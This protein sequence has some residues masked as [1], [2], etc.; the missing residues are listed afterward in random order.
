M[1]APRLLVHF[2]LETQPVGYQSEMIPLLSPVRYFSTFMPSQ[3]YNHTRE[4]VLEQLL[5]LGADLARV[6]GSP[7]VTKATQLVVAAV[8][9]CGPRE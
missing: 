9:G 5:A 2:A 1:R 8:D 4:Q 6:R 7:W 3:Q